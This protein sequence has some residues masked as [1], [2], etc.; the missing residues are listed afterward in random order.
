MSLRAKRGNLVRN[1][2]KFIFVK[3][4]LRYD[5]QKVLPNY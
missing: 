3:L 1:N 4:L 5:I 2:E